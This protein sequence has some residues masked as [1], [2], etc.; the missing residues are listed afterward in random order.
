MAKLIIFLVMAACCVVS[1]LIIPV[2]LTMLSFSGDTE[3]TTNSTTNS[4]SAGS[5]VEEQLSFESIEEEFEVYKALNDGEAR[6][7]EYRDSDDI[8]RMKLFQLAYINKRRADYD[9]LPVALDIL[10][11]RVA[12]RMAME[13][14]ESDFHGHWNTRGETPYQRYAFAGGLDH[15]SENAAAM[16][17]TQ[18]LPSGLG[19]YQRN[20]QSLHDDFMAE[21]APNDGHKVN[22]IDVNHNFVGLGAAFHK[23]QFR[24]YEEFLDRYLEFVD[25]KTSASAGESFKI[26]VKPL[27]PELFVYFAVVYYEDFPRPMS[28]AE[29]NSRGS[30]PDF[31]DKTVLT[32]GP[33]D[34]MREDSSGAYN[35]PMK[36]AERG[37]YYVQIYL[38]DTEYDPKSTSAVSTEGKIQASGLVIRVE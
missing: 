5:T 7:S 36:L 4:T 2:E 33:W 14:S 19:D 31:T 21:I 1:C 18:A 17:S 8:L 27:S 12:N 22:C 24:Y 11:S 13:A 34:I 38:S 16:M 32:L 23:N 15:V 9:A 28:P 29:I 37:L 6:Y 30:Y 25:V 26:K 35:I 20:M 10:A 3:S